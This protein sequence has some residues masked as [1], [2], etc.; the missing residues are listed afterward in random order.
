[1]EIK[2]CYTCYIYRPP[3]ASHC[4]ICDFCIE[5]FDHHCPWIG[6][7]VGKKNYVLFM[8]YLMFFC[9]FLLFLL[10]FSIIELAI[11]LDK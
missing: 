8:L 1:M 4:N 10:I 3:R 6:T 5:K 7:C 2:F 11:V 9:L